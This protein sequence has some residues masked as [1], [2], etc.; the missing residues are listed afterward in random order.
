M[1]W[2]QPSIYDLADVELSLYLLKLVLLCFLNEVELLRVSI[3]QFLKDRGARR[4]N[5]APEPKMATLHFNFR[6]CSLGVSLFL[7][8]MR[9]GATD[10][11]TRGR[12]GSHLR[13]RSSV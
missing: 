10:A 3:G 4:T 7:N 2:L 12:R 1:L 6:L 8:A 11:R 9:W 13:I 5:G